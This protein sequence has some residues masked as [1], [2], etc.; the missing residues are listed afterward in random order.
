MYDLEFTSSI[1][2]V[3]LIYFGFAVSWF[4]FADFLLSQ[5][6]IDVRGIHHLNF[7]KDGLFIIISVGLLFVPLRR[8]AARYTDKITALRQNEECL[9]YVLEG[10]RLGFWDWDLETGKVNRNAIWAEMLG[11]SYNDI[12]FSTQQWTDFVHPE[13]RARAW[14][15]I[16]AVLEGRA[17]EH[18]MIYRMKTHEGGYKWILDQARVVHRDAD[19]KPLRMSGTHYDLNELKQAEDALQASEQRFQSIFETAAVGISQVGL[20]GRF[21]LIND[22]FCHIIGYSREEILTRKLT[23]Q[24]ITH[25]D[26]LAPDLQLLEQ[27]VQGSIPSY[28]LEKRYIR[29]DGGI[30][31]VKLSVASL[32]DVNGQ[33]IGFISAVLDITQLKSL[34]DELQVQ[35][36]VDYLTGIPNRRHFI[37]LAEYELARAQRYGSDLAVLMIDIDHF[38]KINDDHGH[39]AGDIV[40]QKIVKA[41]QDT[42]REVDVMGRMGGE[43]FAIL[44]PQTKKDRAMEV[45]ERLLIQ[46]AEHE[47]VLADDQSVNITLSIGVTTLTQHKNIDALLLQADLGLYQAKNSGRNTV[48]FS[49]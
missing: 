38:K 47:V 11:Y 16:S 1:K 48:V 19:G 25:P 49:E 30:V 35:A 44:L 32:R 29:K 45:A 5:L 34:Q 6:S 14:A 2:K 41:M 43:E 9:T 37:E 12:Q 13:D 31:W 8:C 23:F 20:D 17:D 42:L 39:K 46:A 18:K 4:L 33:H 27:L 21:Q 26:D 15:S 3:L 22:T 24:D 40:L 36:H 28:Q 7:I 10:S